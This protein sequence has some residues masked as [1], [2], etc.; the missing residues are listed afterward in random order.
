MIKALQDYI[1][2]DGTIKV[3]IIHKIGHLLAGM[4]VALVAYHLFHSA[5]YSFLLALFVGIA[6]EWVKKTPYYMHVTT[7]T[8]TACGSFL[9][10]PLLYLPLGWQILLG[11]LASLY[12]VGVLY[13]IYINY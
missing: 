12:V 7:A 13:S 4:V 11:G 10:I 5:V 6:R 9:V 1:D 8:L 2:T 3:F